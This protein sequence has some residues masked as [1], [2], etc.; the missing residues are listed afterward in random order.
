MGWE[1][2]KGNWTIIWALFMSAVSVIQLLLAK[3][4]VKRE[5]L[6]LMRQRVQG[7]ENTIAVLPSQKD[8]H[9]LQLEMSNLRGELR[10]LAPSI[11]QVSRISDLLLENELKDK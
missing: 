1:V 4:Y 9:Q 10:E 11:R 8:L 3:T 7:L 5:E 2:V 6:D